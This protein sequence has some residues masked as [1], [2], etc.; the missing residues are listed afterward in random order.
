MKQVMTQVMN[1]AD[2]RSSAKM[3]AFSAFTLAAA[4]A[5]MMTHL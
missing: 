1:T 4:W 3:H 5:F 2:L